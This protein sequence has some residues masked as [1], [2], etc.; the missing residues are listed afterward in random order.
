MSN[1]AKTR[2]LRHLDNLIA[3]EAAEMAEHA[4][5]GR[6]HMVLAC[7]NAMKDLRIRRALMQAR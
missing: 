7:K 6:S 1:A 4:S 5:A 3:S 2:N